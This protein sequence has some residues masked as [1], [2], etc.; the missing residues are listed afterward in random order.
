MRERKV[1]RMITFMNYYI[2]MSEKLLQLISTT[3][4]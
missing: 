1:L 4:L 2:F 3:S